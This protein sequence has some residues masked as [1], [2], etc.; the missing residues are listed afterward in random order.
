MDEQ[1]TMLRTV[2]RR[3]GASRQRSRA[4]LLTTHVHLAVRPERNARKLHKRFGQGTVLSAR[5]IE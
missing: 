2:S 1:T 5:L 3:K 4:P